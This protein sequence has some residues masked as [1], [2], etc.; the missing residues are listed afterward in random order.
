MLSIPLPPRKRGRGGG[1]SGCSPL[2]PTES[3]EAEGGCGSARPWVPPRSPIFPRG[4][5]D[6]ST[7]NADTSHPLQSKY[8]I[9]LKGTLVSFPYTSYQGGVSPQLHFLLR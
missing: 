6:I 4:R 8:N 1:S 5:V 2:I 7:F 3:R 9:T